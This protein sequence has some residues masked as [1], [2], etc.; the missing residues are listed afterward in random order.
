MH[1]TASL[2]LI[3]MSSQIC[4]WWTG[5]CY[6]EGS[7]GMV[8]STKFLSRTS[9]DYKQINVTF[10]EESTKKYQAFIFTPPVFS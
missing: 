9:S 4:E 8:E 7:G 1:K 2:I 5:L 3:M 10:M 6:L